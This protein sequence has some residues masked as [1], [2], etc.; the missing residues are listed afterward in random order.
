MLVQ[1]CGLLDADNVADGRPCDYADDIA[2]LLYD[3]DPGV[4]HAAL[5][6]Y[7]Q[8]SGASAQRSVLSWRV[9]SLCWWR[10]LSRCCFPGATRV[11]ATPGRAGSAV[12]CALGRMGEC[13]AREM[14]AGKGRWRS[15]A[16]GA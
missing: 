7:S 9:R 14:S 4:R 3:D 2:N 5:A 8:E 11:P 10:D 13:G 15:A 1:V 16:K 6:G 12:R